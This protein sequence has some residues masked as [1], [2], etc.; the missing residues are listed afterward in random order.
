MLKPATKAGAF[1][2]HVSGLYNQFNGLLQSIKEAGTTEIRSMWEADLKLLFKEAENI[3]RDNQEYLNTHSIAKLK[4][5]LGRPAE[6]WSVYARNGNSP[7][8]K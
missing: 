3:F 2:A 1:N 7:L 4:I 8:V 6:Q 5:I